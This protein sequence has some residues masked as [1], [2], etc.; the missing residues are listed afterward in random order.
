[1]IIPHSC[2][3][4]TAGSDTTVSAL[5]TFIL[6]MTL[7][8]E[9]QAKARAAIDHVVGQGRLPDF[10]DDIPYLDA[11]LREVL[12]WRPVVPLAIPHAV[13]TDD[14][15]HDRYYIPRGAVVIGNSWA[16]L[17]DEATFGPKP[18]EFIPERWL[19]KDGKI[20]TAIREP[21]NAFGYG[22]RSCPGRD[23]AQGSVWICIASILAT[24]NI[25]KSV[26]EKGV[27]L[28][29]SGE[30][31]SGMLSHPLPY[32]CEIRPRSDAVRATIQ[33]ALQD[34]SP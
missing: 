7:H 3:P 28:E 16:V 20:N 9:I 6:A 24:F 17:H 22:R 30:Y 1:M 13:T 25:S 5:S 34:L 11:I 12:R 15:Y 23:V 14:I 2:P 26:D 29:P 4:N 31:T 32:R 33:D 19:N 10:D 18:N 8:P 27:T 21:S